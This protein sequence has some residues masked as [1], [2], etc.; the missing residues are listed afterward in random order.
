MTTELGLEAVSKRYGGFVAVDGVSLNVEAGEFLSLLGPSGAG[1]STILRI[2][3]GFVRPDG[4]RVMFRDTDV[5]D[6]PPYRRPVNTVFQQYA[7]FPHMTV[8]ENVAYGLRQDGVA[9]DQ[10]RKRVRAALEMVEMLAFAERRPNQLSGGQQQRVAL[11]RALVKRPTVL[12]LD[13][14][15]GALDRR[16]RQQMQIELKLLQR[17]V[18]ITFIY[19]T[20][21]QEEALAMSD[22][23][24]VMRDGRI[25]QV[26]TAS[27]LYERP[28]TAFVAGFIGLQNFLAGQIDRSRRRLV[29]DDQIVV[30]A[31]RAA[32]ALTGD[33][34]AVAA[35]RPEDIELHAAEPAALTNKAKGVVE[36]VVHLG[37]ILEFVVLLQSGREL[38]CRLPRKTARRL[39]KGQAVWVRWSPEDTALYPPDPDLPQAASA[40]PQRRAMADDVAAP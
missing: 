33:Q 20:H 3:G 9:R 2:I 26:G 31:A 17:E 24:A 1:K 38:L 5:T 34:A 12:L 10:R 6:V 25:E 29:T 30:E 15:L 19:V 23:V 8:G 27:E 28:A 13:E 22:R 21:D 35:V 7:L 39:S 40:R 37:D 36:E 4:G 14:P 11:A 32:P 18:G 16:L